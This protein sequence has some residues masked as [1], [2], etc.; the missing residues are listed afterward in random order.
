VGGRFGNVTSNPD[1]AVQLTYN[2][3]ENNADIF[4][5]GVAS[6]SAVSLSGNVSITGTAGH[7]DNGSVLSTTVAAHPLTMTGGPS[8]SGNF[9]Y[10]NAGGGNSY[11]NGTFA[12]ETPSNSDFHSHVQLLSQ[13]PDFPAIDTTVYKQAVTTWNTP[14]V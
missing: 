13:A 14:P 2:P 11:G 4:S 1:R 5:Y 8:I 3:A 12:G 10:T 6:K 7:L 9:A